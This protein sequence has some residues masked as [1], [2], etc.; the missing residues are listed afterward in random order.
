MSKQTIAVDGI[1]AEL[2]AAINAFDT[3]AI[4]ATFDDGALV[5]DDR[6]EFWGERDIRRWVDR[7]IVGDK[8][9]VEVVDAVQHDGLTIVQGAYDG[10][11]DKNGLPDPLILTHYVTVADDTGKIANLIIIANRSV[12]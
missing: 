9:T 8:V 3:D 7:E 1:V 4:M 2:F 11:Y 6:R 10:D 12:L 5:N